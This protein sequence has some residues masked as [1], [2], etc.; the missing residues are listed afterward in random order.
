MRSP[1]LAALLL[2]VSI[3]AAEPPFTIAKARDVRARL[4]SHAEE[5]LGIPYAYGGATAAGFDCSGL[6]YRVYRDILGFGVPRTT[7]ALS[8]VAEPVSR[9]KLQPG[10]LVFFDTTDKLA[11]V[12]IFAGDGSFIH[13]A[14]E[15]SQTGVIQSSL[16]EPY[17]SRTYAA[18]GRLI[19]PAGYLGLILGIGAGP[20]MGPD[21]LARGLAGEF[22]IAVPLHGYEIGLQTTPSWDATLGVVRIP[23]QISV[24][25]DRRLRFFAGPSLTLGTPTLAVARGS[26]GYEPSGGLIANAGLAWAPLEFRMGGS[27]WRLVCELSYDRYVTKGIVIDDAGSD[28]VARIH[29]GLFVETRIPL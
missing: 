11:H 24:G 8:S 5:Y 18:A 6:V 9:E 15:G 7:L 1:F 14:S 10:D 27:T 21:R 19:S 3:L 4:V 2:T 20:L 23:L 29:A 12:G 17:W 22:A 16:T 26:R 25:L 13:S 28:A